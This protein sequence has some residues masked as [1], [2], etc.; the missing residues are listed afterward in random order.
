MAKKE[1][2]PPDKKQIDKTLKKVKEVCEQLKQ[3]DKQLKGTL[4]LAKKVDKALG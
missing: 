4:A 2:K 1:E 3:C